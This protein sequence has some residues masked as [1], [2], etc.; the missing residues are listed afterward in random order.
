MKKILYCLVA[1]LALVACTPKNGADQVVR[2][3]VSLDDNTQPNQK[4]QQRIS[5]IDNGGDSIEINWQEDDVL[6]YQLDG[7]DID[8]TNPFKLISGAGTKNAFFECENTPEDDL[9]NQKF[10][11]YYNG[12]GN[13]GGEI[14]IDQY[15]EADTV[16]REYLFYSASNCEIERGINL[17]PNFALL[18]VQLTTNDNLTNFQRHISIG[19]DFSYTGD[20][21]ICYLKS[22]VDL[23]TPKTF[24]FVL[25]DGYDLSGKSIMLIRSRGNHSTN[26]NT[27]LYLPNIKLHSDK[28]TI[29]T[30]NLSRTENPEDG[31]YAYTI[32]KVITGSN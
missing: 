26:P 8:K 17:E 27:P 2:I 13:P 31:N 1:A 15:A 18:G 10:T 12:A 28:A 21:Y 25:P 29:I 14:P 3:G 20:A 4:G 7:R 30:I 24:Y 22:A 23:T 6:Y 9:F 19:D 16:N 11:L 5:A 32:A